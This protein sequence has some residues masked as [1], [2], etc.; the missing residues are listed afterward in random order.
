MSDEKTV[1]VKKQ[2]TV[3]VHHAMG[4]RVQREFR[5][6]LSAKLDQGYQVAGLVRGRDGVVLTLEKFEPWTFDDLMSEINE[7]LEEKC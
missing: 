1:Q 7:K 5:E 4:A 3:S 2:V 6:E